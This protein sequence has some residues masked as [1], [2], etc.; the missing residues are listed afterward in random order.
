[1]FE[2]AFGSL[3]ALLLL[4]ALHGINPGMGWLFAVA[5]GLQEGSGR[6]VWRALPPLMLGHALA[7]AAAVV[8]AA[9]AGLVIPAEALRWA[10]AAGLFGMGI[11]HLRRHRHPRWSRMRVGPRDLVIWSF[12]MASAHGAGLMALPFVP[13]AAPA[14]VE[15][16]A[17]THAHAL[18]S[19]GPAPAA[20][21]EGARANQ[22][23]HAAH[24]PT[25]ARDGK[26]LG[27]LA[28]VVH[29]LGYLL[30]TGCVAAVVYYRLGLRLL[31]RAWVNVDALWAGA[32]ILTAIL[33]PLI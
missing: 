32:L 17:T 15:V 3:A 5:L 4:G 28:I 9:L 33:I 11:F 16:H 2:I 6:A 7:V 23:M 20:E 25:S 8:L 30:V 10:V 22:G 29:T 21:P 14:V 13:T 12:L 24:L 19:H 26:L 1:M 27:L 18:G 31:Q